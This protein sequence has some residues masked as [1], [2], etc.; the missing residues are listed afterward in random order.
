[1]AE[2]TAQAS[3]TARHELMEMLDGYEISQALHV[4]AKLRLVEVIRAGAR[5]SE[6]IARYVGAHEP[7][8]LRFL[9]FLVAAK[10]LSEAEP[11]VFS[12]TPMGAMLAADHPQS[13][14]PWAALLGSPII[15]R[16]WGELYTTV[17][18]GQ[19][20]FDTV[21]GEPYFQYLE[22]HPGEAAIFNA[23]MSDDGSATTILGA[24]DFSG[25]ARIVD[26]GGGQG[27]F[28]RSILEAHPDA[29]GVLYDLPSVVAGAHEL[30]GSAVAS[31]CE[32]VG[33]DMF[34]SVPADGDVYV[35]KRIVH[36]WSDGEAVQI[37]KNCRE[38]MG[39]G[40][41]VVLVEHI[42]RP[43]EM[44]PDLMMLVLVTGRERTEEDFRALFAGAGLNLTRVLAAG[45]YSVIEGM[46]GS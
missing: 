19:P 37:L 29:R 22:H 43:A 11:G 3:P 2:S 20:A 35:L 33:G 30:R 23:A 10:I 41:K 8:L 18:T 36:D 14:Y 32:V 44:S 16:P 9:R 34:E 24:Y 5:T 45:S 27:E 38:A 31:R 7:A 13:I 28:L 17:M 4:A 12:V 39:D 6:D 1:M 40:G 46:A 15:W 21:F 42:V 25:G 26:V